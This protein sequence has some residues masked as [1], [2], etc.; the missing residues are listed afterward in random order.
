MDLS[1]LSP[2]ELHDFAEKTRQE[3]QELQSARDQLNDEIENLR[4]IQEQIN[5]EFI[6]RQLVQGEGNE[7][8]SVRVFVDPGD[9]PDDVLLDLEQ[10]GRIVNSTFNEATNEL[11]VDFVDIRDAEDAVKKLSKQY[12]ISIISPHKG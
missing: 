10:F 12:N 9:H 7:A 1:E 4:S 2:Q 3:L 11:I 5:Y 8:T 6:D